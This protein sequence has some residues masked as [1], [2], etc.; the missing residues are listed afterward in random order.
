[1]KGTEK[2]IAHIEADAQAQ[3]DAVL[4]EAR[5]RCEAI[6]ARFDDKAARLYSD[7]IR[8]GVKACQDQEDSALRISRMEAR[9]SVLACK[10]KLVSEAFDRAEQKLLSL[11]GEEYIAFLAGQA[12]MASVSGREELI[13]SAKDRDSIGK[14]V[15]SR[16]NELLKEQKRPAGLTL[17]PE[18]GD[19]TGGLIVRDG[20]ITVNC[21]VA[22][23]S[24]VL[25][26][27]VKTCCV[28]AASLYQ[29]AKV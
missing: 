23:L 28:S 19:F 15:V 26:E 8:E 25:S 9:K 27:P 21:T 22:A 1:M 2:I 17:S 7:R 4:G 10:Q 14:K 5:Q 20:S 29:P 12:A 6:K 24:A 3:A 18:A 13:L 16:A 11:S